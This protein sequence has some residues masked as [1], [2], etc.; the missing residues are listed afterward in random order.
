MNYQRV[1]E[2]EERLN[3]Y[4]KMAHKY[5]NLC[6]EQDRELKHLRG[7]LIKK[8]DRDNNKQLNLF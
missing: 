8:R 5:Q 2:L 3:F 1:R 7:V 6:M 4:Q